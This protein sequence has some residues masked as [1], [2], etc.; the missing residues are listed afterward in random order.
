MVA[1]IGSSLSRSEHSRLHHMQHV[2]HSDVESMLGSIWDI[3]HG[4]HD[5]MLQMHYGL[6]QILNNHIC[7]T[8]MIIG[9]VKRIIG[10]EIRRK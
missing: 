2:I 10:M 3:H 4:V 5:L 8:F 9:C 7:V 1:T 6:T